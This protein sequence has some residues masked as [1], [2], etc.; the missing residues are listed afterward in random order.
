M[1]EELI[2]VLCNSLVLSAVVFYPL[3]LS[4]DFTLFWLVFLTTSSIGIGAHHCAK[5]CMVWPAE[6]RNLGQAS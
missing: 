2:I 4:G 6:R 3:K 5:S 1:M